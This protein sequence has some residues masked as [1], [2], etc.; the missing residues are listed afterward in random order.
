MSRTSTFDATKAVEAIL[1]VVTRAKSDL[2]V[3]LKLLYL[4]DKIHLERYGRLITDDW[5]AAL[6]HGPVPSQAYAIL[7]YVRGDDQPV[8]VKKGAS[9]YADR[10]RAKKPLAPQANRALAV[11]DRAITALRSPDL[12]ELS[13]SDIECL[14]EAVKK[15]KGFGF[16]ALKEITHDDAYNATSPN[17]E[18]TIESIAAML[19]NGRELVRHVTDPHPDRA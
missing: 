11:R 6:Q 16:S 5:Y 18:I 7:Q 19:K 8:T 12:D 15:F 4:A 10:N 17:K 13:K 2:Y 1:Y 14:D 9:D 3:T